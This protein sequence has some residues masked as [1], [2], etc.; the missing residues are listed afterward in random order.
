MTQ[1]PEKKPRKTAA[2]PDKTEKASGTSQMA[3]A[4]A[5]PSKPVAAEK[6]PR[7][8]KSKA[9]IGSGKTKKAAADKGAA[10]AAAATP[11]LVAIRLQLRT[12]PGCAVYVAGSFNAWRAKEFALSEGE[13][14]TY[15][16]ELQ[17][18]PGEYE[19]KFIVNGRWQADPVA[20]GW[21][22]N[23]FGSLNSVLKVEA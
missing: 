12:E 21:A 4:S 13:A 20:E 23:P 3:G 15:T 17:L 18:A 6:A 11:S 10:Q 14:G 22:P 8:T 9:E 2:K 19:Y 7:K 16:A 1:K 5:A